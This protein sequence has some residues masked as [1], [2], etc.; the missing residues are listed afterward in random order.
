MELVRFRNYQQETIQFSDGVNIFYGDNAQGKTNILEAV[1][2]FSMGKSIRARREQELILNGA[3]DGELHL[4]FSDS[5]RR[6][7][8][9]IY[10]GRNRRKRILVNDIPLRKNSELM[11]RFCVVYFG[12]ENLDMVKDGPAVRRRN[13]DMFIS[14]LHPG[15]FSALSQIRQ[16]IEQKTA[17]LRADSPDTMMLEVLNERFCLAAVEVIEKRSRYLRKIEEKAACF[18]QEIS[19]G[20]EILAMQY[21]SCIGNAAERSQEDILRA[22][23]DKMEENSWREL[24]RREC[25][26]GPHREDIIFSINGLEAKAFAS[27]GQ[28]KTVVLVEKLAE[29]SLLLEETGEVP[30]LLLDD[31]MSELDR[32]RQKYILNSIRDMQILITCTDTEGFKQNEPAALFHV[33]AGAVRQMS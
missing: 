11:G 7:E 2:M 17:L 26:T 31:I 20:N 33:E 25:L 15:Y 1:S 21:K 8:S 4:V 10:L 12:P 3:E 19:G 6:H 5:Q 13:I 29:V 27:Q 24:E 23:R 16:I 30:V 9:G 18:Q 14:Q 28:Q 32:K 22:V